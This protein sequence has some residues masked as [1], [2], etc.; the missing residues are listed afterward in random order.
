MTA[1]P[2][3][4][5]G[6]D[7][8]PRAVVLVE[9]ASDQHALRT[10]AAGRGRDLDAE[11]VAVLA[12]GGATNVARYLE[13]YGPHGRDVR[14]AGLCDA[15]EERYFRRGLER[16]GLGPVRDRAELAARGFWV[17]DADLESELIRAL[18]V[19]AVE[20]I[21]QDAGELPA[22]RILQHQPAHRGRPVHEQLW[23]F[24]GTRSGRKLRYAGLLVA[25]LRDEQVPLAL[26][27]VL[28]RT[29]DGKGM[30]SGRADW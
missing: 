21:V 14:L 3:P 11:G 5:G 1:T 8:L 30:A 16:A 12:M 29:A 27:R 19:S 17:C 6:A 2:L 25:A 10:L 7:R 18:G 26:I 28:E 15:A 23:R 20:R 13:R 9:G 22:F 24:I 4:A